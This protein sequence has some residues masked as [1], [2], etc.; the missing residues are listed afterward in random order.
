[1]AVRMRFA[2]ELPFGARLTRARVGERTLSATPVQN[3]QDTHATLDLSLP[4]GETSVEIHYDG[5]ILI[6][7]A[8]KEPSV[9]D[10]SEGPR[11]TGVHVSD[12]V[13]TVELEHWASK[14]ATFE[15]HT[16][17]TITNVTGAEFAAAGP[18]VFRFT[19]DGHGGNDKHRYEHGTVTV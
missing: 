1:P 3:A 17:W 15:L 6:V 10:A 2:P 18:G 16:P 5:G 8:L 4:H 11:I 13:F 7:P 19:V 12:G 9:G 14:A